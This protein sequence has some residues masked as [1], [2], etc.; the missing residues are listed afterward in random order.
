M[1][2]YET[3]LKSGI[4]RTKEFE[5]KQLAQFAVNIGTRCGHQCTYC[6]TPALLRMHKSFKEA[7]KSPFADEYAIVDPKV[8]ERVARDAK[9]IRKRGKIQLCTTADAWSPEAQKYNLGRRCLEAILSQPEWTVRILTKNKAVEKDFDLIEKYK[10]RISLGI[11][12]TATPE[13]SNVISLIEPYASSIKERITVLYTAASR[14]IRTYAMF[15]PLLPGI[16]NSS[17][18]IDE[19]IKVANQNNAEEIFAEPVNARGRGLIMTQE[20]LKKHG[21]EPEALAVNEIRNKKNWSKYVVELISNLQRSVR[22]HYDI[23]RL[24]ILLYPK[25]LLQEDLKRIQKDDAGVVWLG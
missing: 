13:K 4:T 9:K 16:G 7:G 25:K 12:I 2:I 18:H 3:E 23:N 5:K 24:R 8:P 14:G 1:I 17:E 6:S 19:L 15:C 20:I 22:R 21:H 11:S 10:D